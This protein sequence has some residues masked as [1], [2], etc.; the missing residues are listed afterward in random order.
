MLKI[1]DKRQYREITATA[2]CLHRI[3]T[4]VYAK[5]AIMLPADTEADFEEVASVPAY[6]EVEYEAEVVRL[7]RER[8]NL[9]AELA[10]LRQRDTKPEE[11]AAYNAFAEACKSQAKAKVAAQLQAANGADGK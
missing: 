11:F 1:T 10:I 5:A 3:G 8:Y 4:D 9:N 2:G 6:T 7:I